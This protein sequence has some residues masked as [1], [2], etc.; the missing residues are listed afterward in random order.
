MT[1]FSMFQRVNETVFTVLFVAA[2]SFSAQARDLCADLKLLQNAKPGFANL[3]G[4]P[5]SDD[6]WR[7][8]PA[9]LGGIG[10]CL[11]SRSR[12]ATHIA[13]ASAL[14][15][16]EQTA[17]AKRANVVKAVG[18]C[19][20]NQWSTSEFTLGGAVAT[21]SFRSSI[22]APVVFSVSLYRQPGTPSQWAIWFGALMSDDTEERTLVPKAPTGP[23]EFG[24]RSGDKSL[25]KDLATVMA[26][27][28]DKFESMKGRKVRSYWLPKFAIAGLTNCDIHSIDGLDYYSCMATTGTSEDESTAVFTALSADIQSCINK[29]WGVSKRQRRN[30]LP[31]VEFSNPID[32]VSI[33]IR[34]RESEGDYS[35]L[36]DVEAN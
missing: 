5:T 20:G 2:I 34:M 32:P 3:R 22:Q 17:N 29:Q 25:C 1:H 21:T 11:I 12:A 36:L 18:N 15:S 7:T 33:V 4:A 6:K 9:D 26:G 8:N 19:L 24:W 23:I 14:I 16:D 35:V 30:G 27:V 10:E 28:K 13:C 31:M